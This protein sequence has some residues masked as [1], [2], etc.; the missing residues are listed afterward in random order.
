MPHVAPTPRSSEALR[1]GPA[2]AVRAAAPPKAAVPPQAAISPHLEPLLAV[3]PDA[4][5][6]YLAHLLELA[7][8]DVGFAITMH[9]DGGGVVPDEWL[10]TAAEATRPPVEEAVAVAVRRSPE[11]DAQLR[12]RGAAR[13]TTL[14]RPAT[15]EGAMGHEEVEH[16]SWLLS[17]LPPAQQWAPTSGGGGSGGGGGGGG[18]G[19]GGSCGSG[20]A[21]R[22][23]R[24]APVLVWVRAGDLRLRDNPA[25][26]AA[27]ES[28][29]PV[30][31]VYIQPS[32]EEQRG[33][34]VQGAAAYWLHH[35]LL[36]LQHGLRDTLK[37]AL[38]L[39]AADDE[40]GDS[41]A[42]LLRLA[43]ES[44]AS[45]VHYNAAYEPWRT[46][47]D[48]R[49]SEA[50]RVRGVGAVRHRG[51][52]LYEPWDARPDERSA[53]AGFGSVGFFLSAVQDLPPPPEPLP[54]PAAPLRPPAAWPASL[55]LG[56]LGLARLPRRRDGATVDWARG[57]RCAWAVGEEGAQA[58]LAAFVADGLRSFEGRERHRADE[59]NTA[60]IS[61]YLRFGELS[62][63]DVRA[64][65]RE[66]LGEARAPSFEPNPNPNSNPK[67]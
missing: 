2:A 49:V 25:L 53:S 1:D 15:V 23:A 13:A 54:P 50:L 52:L 38:V 19:G 8:G 31:P 7:G 58:A 57:L 65:V 45:A 67:P 55:R 29:R 6:A 35:S 5:P 39:R 64:A 18:S 63:R 62:A 42:A 3:V 16:H 37:T 21:A 27:A 51:N 32:K 20:A 28:G 24:A 12:W 61:P 11:D 26:V 43:R 14:R 34:A 56:A 10:A 44:G 36:Q 17:E 40:G 60:A 41:A 30:V 22:G 9:F 59:Q 33:W 47:C 4:P 48:Q 46:D 66:A